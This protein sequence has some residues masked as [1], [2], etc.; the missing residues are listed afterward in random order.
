MKVKILNISVACLSGVLLS[1][2]V[3]S[4][5]NLTSNSSSSQ[6]LYLL[7]TQWIPG[8][9]QVPQAATVASAQVD[10]DACTSNQN[11]LMY[12]NLLHLQI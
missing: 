1:C 5:S 11:P 4:N 12:Y 3:G 10:P 8:W 2:N 7:A 6:Q 9:C